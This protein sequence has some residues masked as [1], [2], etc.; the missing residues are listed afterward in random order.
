MGLLCALLAG[1]FLRWFVLHLLRSRQARAREELGPLLLEVKVAPRTAK[2][3]RWVCLFWLLYLLV[4]PALFATFAYCLLSRLAGPSI[5]VLTACSYDFRLYF[6]FIAGSFFVSSLALPSRWPFVFLEIREHGILSGWHRVRFWDRIAQFR[7]CCPKTVRETVLCPRPWPYNRYRV[8]LWERSIA[9]AQKE[10]VTAMLARFVQV[11]DHDGTLLAGPSQAE[12]LANPARPAKPHARLWLQFNLQSLLLLTVAVS[13]AA[14]CYGIH[15]R[16]L[17]PQTNAVAQ[18]ARFGPAIDCF[19]DV[20]W[21]VDFSK[22][23]KKPCD[24]DLACL[25]SL[26]NLDRVNLAGSPITDAGLDHLKGLRHL[27]LVDC[28]D[29]GVTAKGAAELFR[30]LPRAA[31]CFGPAKNPVWFLPPDW[32]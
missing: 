15:Y 7:W 29:T 5:D 4:V 28:R 16:R 2:T 26:A 30:A 8:V 14:S 31:V 23:A 12:L 20:P 9:A 22:C 1:L 3:I 24:D 18:M 10:A 25:E 13:C 11:F 6:A 27:W 17:A 19:G 21:S 32:P